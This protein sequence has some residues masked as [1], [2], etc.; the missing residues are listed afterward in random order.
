MILLT[1]AGLKE[2]TL[3]NSNLNHYIDS[4]HA[5]GDVECLLKKYK[6][7]SLYMSMEHDPNTS[8]INL[9]C[10]RLALDANI[11][12]VPR[13]DVDIQ[14]LNLYY[15]TLP[16]KA[17]LYCMQ[18]NV[19]INYSIGQL[20]RDWKNLFQMDAAYIGLTRRYCTPR[21]ALTEFHNWDSSPLVPV[22]QMKL[23]GKMNAHTR[24][25]VLRVLYG[26]AIAKS[27]PDFFGQKFPRMIIR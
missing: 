15:R 16:S 24:E 8:G 23:Y 20:K 21:Q 19:L 9:L 5:M 25:C 3:L 4:V 22:L 1:S 12:P 27:F 13:V 10:V 14:N 11:L 26:C 17:V 2:V 7:R 18:G 6:N